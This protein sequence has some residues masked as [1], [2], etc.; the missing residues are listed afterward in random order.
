MDTPPILS[1]VIVTY[2]S[3]SVV[4]HALESIFNCLITFEYEIIV[5]DNNSTDNTI[6]II[7]NFESDK[8][9]LIKNKKNYGFAKA[10]NIGFELCKGEYILILNPDIV[11]TEKTNL[12]YLIHY[13]KNK[14]SV[15]IIAPKLLYENDKT[16]ES[17]RNFPNPILL[18]I[19]GLN[20]EKYF[21]RFNFYKNFLLIDKK[22]IAPIY[23]D[24]VIGAFIL[25]RKDI[26]IQI[27]YF[28]DKYFMYYEDADLSLRLLKNGYK[29]FYVPYCEAIH[30]YQRESA[31]KTFSKLK[32]YHI[33]S[34]L[35]FFRKHLIFLIRY[36]KI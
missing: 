14:S 7:S 5:V 10:N 26:L 29:T 19:R 11:L 3:A 16:Q 4:G 34:I 33:K 30:K 23:V 21:A 18:L 17:A 8:L 27:N 36:K 12:P 9:I 32:Y 24:W 15:G 13:I 22:D 25:I 28:D 31:K 1:V 6:E 20:L 35:R 2:N